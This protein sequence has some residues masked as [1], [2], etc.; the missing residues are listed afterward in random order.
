[1][2]AMF[3]D[4]EKGSKVDKRRQGT[5]QRMQLTAGFLHV[6]SWSSLEARERQ[7]HR[8]NMKENEETS[9][10]GAAAARCQSFST[11]RE[12]QERKNVN[13]GNRRRENLTENERNR[14]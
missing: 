9:I 13:T 3:A 11:I 5:P 14:A 8:P 1:M 12:L 7:G 4:L 6:R 10:K 2:A